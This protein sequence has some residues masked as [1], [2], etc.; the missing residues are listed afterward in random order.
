M[1]SSYISRIVKTN[2][3]FLI[4][5]TIAI[6]IIYGKS[7]NFNYTNLD[8]DLLISQNI[9]FTSE[10]QNIP[11]LFLTSCYY[12]NDSQY[13]RPILSLSFAMESMFFK[14][15][16]NG[17]HLVNI[18]IYILTIYLMYI[19]LSKLKFNKNILKFVCLLVAVHPIFSSCI[20]WIPARNDTLLAIFL[21]L[22]FINFVNYIELKKSKY[23]ILYCLFFTLSLFTKE[24]AIAAIPMYFIFI[25]SFGYKIKPRNIINNLLILFL[26]L[27]IYF[28]LRSLSVSSIGTKEYILNFSTYGFN[29][30]SG[31]MTY[32][33]KF[34]V[35]D[36]I[37]VMLYSIQ[38]DTLTIAINIIAFS[39]LSI[40][41]YKNFIDRKIIIFSLLWF[42]LFL[43]PTFFIQEYLFLT[44]R[45]IISSL[46]IIIIITLIINKI[47]IKYPISKKYLIGFFIIL[48]TIYSY[49]S[50]IQKNKYQNPDIFWVNSYI[51]APNYHA[52]LHGLANI[53]ISKD[54]YEKAK[55]LLYKAED[56]KKNRY[57]LAI[58]NILCFEKKFN[59]AEFLLFKSINANVHKSLCYKT[60]SAIYMEQNNIEKALEYAQKAYNLEPNNIV[61][62]ELLSDL[63][64]MNNNYEQAV[65]V[66]FKLL[67]LNNKNP[68]YYY[69]LSKLFENLKDNQ[70][71]I[72]YI[73]KAIKLNNSNNDY[74]KQLQKLITI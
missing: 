74:K 56:I 72:E 61:F 38:I 7:I 17:Y 15:T 24:T 69:N 71:A 40:L 64:T 58:A 48:F 22:S 73:Q 36:Y 53:Y 26:I 49:A 33:D 44:H 1:F 19:F 30:L 43:L 9:S 21:M 3:F 63:Y 46:G 14:T 47:I 12:S 27:I 60:L 20:A 67:K 29:I 37:P 70:K 62:S 68:E 25:Y 10:I 23:F 18:A 35:P 51:D 50:Y 28:I 66:N 39:L 16:L 54:E 8:D 52:A 65:I 41:Y 4:I 32:I 31:I 11:K 6:F 45:L 59:E 5:L 34:I 42:M 57:L 2:I 13:Y 55:I